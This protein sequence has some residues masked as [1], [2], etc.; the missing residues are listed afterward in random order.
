MKD[1]EVVPGRPAFATSSPISTVGSTL[2]RIGAGWDGDWF[3][4]GDEFSFTEAYPDFD[5]VQLAAY[6]KK[7]GVH[8]VG[9][10][11]LNAM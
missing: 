10:Q 7:K 8:L 5:I 11:L 2:L 9:H 1:T 3:A 4:T 6:A